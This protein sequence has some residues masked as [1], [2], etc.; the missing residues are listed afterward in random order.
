MSISKSGNLYFDNTSLINYYNADFNYKFLSAGSAAFYLD[1][2]NKS[3]LINDGS[4]GLNY[5]R[6]AASDEYESAIYLQESDGKVVIGSSKFRAKKG[7]ALDTNTLLS[8]GSGKSHYLYVE[9]T[10]TCSYFNKSYDPAAVT[11]LK[12]TNIELPKSNI[13]LYPNPSKDYINIQT[14]QDV[15]R[16]DIYDMSGKILKTNYSANKMN[17]EDLPKGNYL[18]KIQLINNDIETI[19]F[20]KN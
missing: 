6:I 17:I 4:T 18:V 1:S 19:K 5:M 9:N 3:F 12:K 20:T 15:S 13:K 8:P 16:I 7:I 10:D 11:N 2:N 14:E